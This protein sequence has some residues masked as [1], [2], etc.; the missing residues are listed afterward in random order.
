MKTVAVQAM[1]ACH[2]N[3]PNDMV[4]IKFLGMTTEKTHR[5]EQYRVRIDQDGVDQIITIKQE[6]YRDSIFAEYDDSYEGNFDE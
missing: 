4:D 2:F 3:V 1:I 5:S 6:A